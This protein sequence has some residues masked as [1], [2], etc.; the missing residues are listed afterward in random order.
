MQAPVFRAALLF[1]F[2]EGSVASAISQTTPPVADRFIGS[3]QALDAEERSLTL[4]S[5]GGSTQRVLFDRETTCLR[6]QPG[7]LDLKTAVMLECRQLALNDRVLARGKL[8]ASVLQARQLIVMTRADLEQKQSQERAEWRRRGAAGVVK[9]V[10]SANG[11]LTV[12]VRSFFRSREFALSTAERKAMFR[13]YPPDATRFDETEAS[14]LDA[15]RVGDQIQALGDWTDDRTR[16]LAEQVVSGSF[17]TLIGSVEGLGP[18]PQQ[19]IL[20]P[21][22]DRGQGEKR[23]GG[24]P[25]TITVVPAA[26]VR[27]FPAEMA[28]RL[29]GRMGGDNAGLRRGS[30]PGERSARAGGVREGE[31]AGARNMGEMWERLP[32][33][34]LGDLR[35][36]EYVAVAVAESRAPGQARATALLAGIEPLIRESQPR[37]GEDAPSF[38]LE[39]LDLGMGQP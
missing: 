13:R 6:A 23:K 11:S 38:S 37:A 16:F 27:R 9:A 30:G 28:A 25:V 12:E 21:L 3:V 24:E 22:P 31:G 26:S 14:V 5:D 4:L 17:R 18:D 32:G 1:L 15:I 19:F 20:K 29:T 7:A 8:S 2:M 36:G 33:I 35:A 10:D 34:K 39:G